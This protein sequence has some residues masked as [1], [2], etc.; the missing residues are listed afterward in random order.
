MTREQKFLQFLEDRLKNAGYSETIS[1]YTTI[2]H[3]F[4]KSFTETKE[5]Y[6]IQWSYWEDD[7]EY[8]EVAVGWYT[9]EELMKFCSG[10][11][12]LRVTHIR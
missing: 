1:A 8:T 4:K 3:H 6:L 5:H 10:R 7:S 2:M 9:D 11:R 12:K